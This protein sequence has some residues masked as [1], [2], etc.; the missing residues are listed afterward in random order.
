MDEIEH[1]RSAAVRLPPGTQLRMLHEMPT[2]QV[3]LHETPTV[4]MPPVIEHAPD[5][6]A[7]SHGMEPLTLSE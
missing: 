5:P 4:K 3:A 6:V 7:V 1:E 2:V